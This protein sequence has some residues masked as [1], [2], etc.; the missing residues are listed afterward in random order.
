[1]GSK[2]RIA[3]DIVP[4]IQKCIDDNNIDIYIEPFVGGSNM[5]EHIRC[6]TKKGYDSNNYLIEFWREL[7]N[8]WN[9]LENIN[10]TR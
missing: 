1:M 8:G 2:S 4:I 5:I 7:Q 9:P 10:M 3:K 6:N